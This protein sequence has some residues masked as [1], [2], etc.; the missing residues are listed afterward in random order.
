[1]TTKEMQKTGSALPAF[2]KSETARGSEGVGA[3]DLQIPRIG[4]VQDLSPERKKNQ[5]E[6]IDGADSG[7]MYNSVTRQLYAAALL[8]IPVI[9]RKEYLLWKPRSEGGGFRGMFK[10]EQSAIQAQRQLPEAT[11]LVDTAQQFCLV[12]ADQGKSWSEAVVS[13]AKSNAAVSRGWNSDIRMRCAD[14]EG[15]YMCD[16][17]ATMYTLEVLEKTNDKGTFF[18]FKTQF[19]GYV[20]DEAVYK[21]AETV[22][23]A[24]KAGVKDVSRDAPT[25][26]P[27]ADMEDF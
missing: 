14:A 26:A 9:F 21:R 3:D 22:Y 20:Q 4:I 7:M 18:V 1:M 6:Y 25:D 5:P 16:R 11:D 2:A 12:S 23:D 8:V 27:A 24:V 10:D 19:A 17:F 13:M 15:N